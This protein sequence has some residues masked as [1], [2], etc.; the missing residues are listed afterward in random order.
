MDRTE[1]TAAVVNA[2]NALTDIW[3]LKLIASFF[4]AVLCSLHAK[5]LLLFVALVIVD[6]LTKWIALAKQ[7]LL[8][9][10]QE[11]GFLRCILSIKKARRAGYIRS[12]KMKHRFA[13]K[14]IVYMLLTFGAGMVDM[15]FRTMQ[16]PDFLVVVVVGYLSVTEMLSTVE[17]LQEAGVKEAEKLHDIIERKGGLK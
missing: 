8:D 4:I 17:N 9:Q 1:L 16:K 2:W 13:G 14:I 12:D 6:L 5:L 3:L 10:R 15:M 7:Y 11:A